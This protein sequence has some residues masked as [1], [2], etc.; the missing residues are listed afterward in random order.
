MKNTIKLKNEA[1]HCKNSRF[2]LGFDDMKGL[3]DLLM[4][5]TNSQTCSPYQRVSDEEPQQMDA[6]LQLLH[7]IKSL[8]V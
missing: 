7:Q 3:K 4:A 8:L 2:H 5:L 6:Q 1:I